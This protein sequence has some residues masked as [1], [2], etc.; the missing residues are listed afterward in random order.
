MFRKVVELK[1]DHEEAQALLAAAAPPE[2]SPGEG[3][4]GLISRLFK[5]P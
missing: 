5:K 1:P 3:G 4:G 2:P